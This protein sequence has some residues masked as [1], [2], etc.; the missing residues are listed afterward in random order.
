MDASRAC[1]VGLYQS[2]S[3]SVAVVCPDPEGVDV[4]DILQMVN[5]V[6]EL[7]KGN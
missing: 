1:S 5:I 2:S 3:A 7:A 4:V 6:D